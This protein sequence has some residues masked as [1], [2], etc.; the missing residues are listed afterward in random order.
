MEKCTSWLG[1]KFE[2]RYD[3]KTDVKDFREWIGSGSI[4]EFSFPIDF[5]D[6]AEKLKVIDKQYV[7]DICIKCGLKIK[8]D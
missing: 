7:C 5:S 8:R 3:T 1:H 6:L 4:R 2:P